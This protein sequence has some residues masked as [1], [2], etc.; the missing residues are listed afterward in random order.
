VLNGEVL[1]HN[2]STRC[3]DFQSAKTVDAFTLAPAW[4]LRK[5]KKKKKAQFFDRHFPEFVSAQP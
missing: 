5:K 2:G 1:A 3:R 4:I